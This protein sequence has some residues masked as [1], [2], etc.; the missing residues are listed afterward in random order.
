VSEPEKGKKLDFF[1]MFMMVAC[2]VLVILVLM[3]ARENV[4]LKK[5][6]GSFTAGGA[7]QVHMEGQVFPALTVFDPA[8]S[9]RRIDFGQ[10][11]AGR[12]TLLLVYSSQCPACVQTIPIWEDV[13]FELRARPENDPGPVEV[14]AIQTDMPDPSKPD[15]DLGAMLTMALPFPVFGIRDP[16]TMEELSRIPYIPAALLIDSDGKVVRTWIGVPNEEVEGEL[17]QLIG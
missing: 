11:E 7:D 15:A 2:L 13:F 1:S 14:L 3:L 17:K 6:L 10:G 4:M 12:Q 5:E 8:G 16:A 9:D